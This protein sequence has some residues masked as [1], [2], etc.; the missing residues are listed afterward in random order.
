MSTSRPGHRADLEALRGLAILL[1]VAYHAG[2]PA[3]AGGFVG[4]DVFFVLSGYFTGRLLVHE[5]GT[6]GSIA[7]WTFWRRRALRL[8][9]ALL[10][11]VAATLA[12]AW[13]LWAPIDRAG[14]AGTAR[15]VLLADA[16]HAFARE[17]V[18]YFS[19]RRS[20]RA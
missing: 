6:T 3:L 20:R 7:P 15:S 14:I 17:G 16:N 12:L 18:D 2:L 10:V 19:S 13:T 11:V 5:Y 9:P 1:V 8:L 4:V